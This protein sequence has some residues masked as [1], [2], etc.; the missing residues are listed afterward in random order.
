MIPRTILTR[1]LKIQVRTKL[2]DTM[3]FLWKIIE[4][5]PNSS[6]NYLLQWN[7]KINL[8]LPI[9]CGSVSELCFN[10]DRKSRQSNFFNKLPINF[11]GYSNVELIFPFRAP[12]TRFTASMWWFFTLIMVSSYTANLAAFLTVENPFEKITSV[13]DLKNCGSSDELCPV[14]FGAKKGGATFNFFKESDH[15]TY[16]SMYKYMVRE[17]SILFV[18][19][20]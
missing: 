3:I 15:P 6:T 19:N 10:K 14:K 4:N 11:D 18:Y 20:Y 9:Q 17:L 12:A 13:E 8:H 7:L 2:A 16:R 5:K 1:A